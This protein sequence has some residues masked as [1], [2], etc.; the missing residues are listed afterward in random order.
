MSFLILDIETVP[1]PSIDDEVEAEI[2]NKTKAR[3]ERTGDDPENAESF[4]PI[5]IPI[6]WSGSMYRTTFFIR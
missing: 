5:Y 3:V 1:R 2:I 4:N 6:F